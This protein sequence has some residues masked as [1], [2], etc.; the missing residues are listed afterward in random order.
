V[1]SCYLLDWG[2]FIAVR[3]N[4]GVKM[5]SITF[6][7]ILAFAKILVKTK[8]MLKEDLV[9]EFKKLRV[10]VTEK[11]LMSIGDEKILE[12]LDIKEN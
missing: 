6:C 1:C 7:F 8:L 11:A 9:K 5:N 3:D 12:F 4:L 2:S 10:I